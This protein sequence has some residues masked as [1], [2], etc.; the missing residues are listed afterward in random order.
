MLAINVLYI[1]E[2]SIFHECMLHG[3]T[4]RNMKS[5]Q[6]QC[7]HLMIVNKLCLHSTN[8]EQIHK[9]YSIL[10]IYILYSYVLYMKHAATV[11]S[12]SRTESIWI[13]CPLWIVHDVHD[14]WIRV[15]GTR[16][17]IFTVL[18]RALVVWAPN[19]LAIFAAWQNLQW[20]RSVTHKWPLCAIDWQSAEHTVVHHTHAHTHALARTYASHIHSIK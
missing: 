19:A 20:S 9:L 3:S 8:G 14:S 5:T 12:T 17:P 13:R 6:R 10:F 15:Y 4:E 11:K 2:Y 1:H 18:Y 16:R 7:K